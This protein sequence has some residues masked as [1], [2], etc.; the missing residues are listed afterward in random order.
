MDTTAPFSRHQRITNT[1]LL[2]ASFIDNIGLM[3]GKMGISIYFFHLA[4]ETQ[5]RI[6]KDYAEDLI[7]EIYE[8]INTTTPFDFEDG[9]AGIGWGIEY[10]AQNGFIDADTDEVL[11]TIDSQ[12]C[13][14]KEQFKGPGL[15]NGITGLGVYYLSR[16]QNPHSTNEKTTTFLNKQILIQIIDELELILG[17]NILKLANSSEDYSL[18]W[19]YTILLLFFTEVNQ[20]SLGYHKVDQILQQLIHP[21]LEL[22]DLPKQHSKCLLLTFAFSRMKYCILPQTLKDSIDKLIQ[23]LLTRLDR[24]TIANELTSN[25]SALQKGTSGIVWIYQQLFHITGNSFYQIEESYWKTYSFK[26]DESSQYLSGLYLGKEN[27]KNVFGLLSG[28]AGINL[29]QLWK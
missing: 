13:L 9:L 15:L 3:H 7:D 6:Y 8:E 1:L 29:I 5:N 22:I 14:S 4:R 26:L 18:T 16:I 21:F 28:L 12:L 17:N 11:E 19:D 25:S 20:L 24:L 10:L 23:R 2:N 27:E